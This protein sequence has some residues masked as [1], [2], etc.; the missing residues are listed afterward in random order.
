MNGKFIALCLV[1]IPIM[2][3]LIMYYLQVYAYYRVVVSDGVSDVILTRKKDGG[4]EP[5]FYTNFQGIDSESSPIRY[6]AC[7]KVPTSINS[8]KELY[9]VVEDAEPLTAPA[10]FDCYQAESLGKKIQE[11]LATSFLSIENIIFGI[12]RVVTV[13]PNGDAFSWT[14]INRCGHLAFNGKSLPKS[15]KDQLERK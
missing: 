8:L 5:I 13:L 2:F 11:G 4:V 3:G 15:C 1:L 7:F 14:K 10:W 6:R 12:D 9:V